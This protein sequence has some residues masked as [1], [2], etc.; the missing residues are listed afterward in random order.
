MTR[1]S[2]MS[3]FSWLAYPPSTFAAFYGSSILCC[4][5]VLFPSKYRL[6]PPSSRSVLNYVW[7]GQSDFRKLDVTSLAMSGVARFSPL[8]SIFFFTTDERPHIPIHSEM[9]GNARRRNVIG[10]LLFYTHRMVS[11]RAR[12]SCPVPGLPGGRAGYT[13]PEGSRVWR[14]VCE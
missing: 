14:D 12:A 11:A 6:F 13:G 5:Q 2:R 4:D 3:L 7:V 8:F 1:R 9:R 10:G